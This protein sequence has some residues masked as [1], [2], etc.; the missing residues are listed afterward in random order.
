[1]KN[2]KTIFLMI[3]VIVTAGGA[4]FAGMKYQASKS[5]S[6]T[7][8]FSNMQFGN[9][10]GGNQQNRS[11]MGGRSVM[12]EILNQDDKSITVKLPDGSSKIILFSNK[13]I[14]NKATEASTTDLKTGEQVAVFGNENSDG[15]VTAENIQLNPVLRM[16]R[17]QTQ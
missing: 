12:G 5:P 17:Q 7:R 9:R 8:Q 6:F 15:S 4:F 14:V 11:R 2:Q 16:I 3:G 10:I 13:T 1:M